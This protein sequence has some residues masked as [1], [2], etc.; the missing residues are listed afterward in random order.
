MT[1]IS[2]YRNSLEQLKG[3]KKALENLLLDKKNISSTI[4]QNYKNTLEARLHIQNVAKETNNQFKIKIDNSVTTALRS[5]FGDDYVFDSEFINKRNSTECILSVKDKYNNKMNLLK[6]KGG[7]VADIVSFALRISL[8]SLSVPRSASVIILDEPAKNISKQYK[9]LFSQFM[10]EVSDKLNIQFIMVTH[11]NSLI[12]CSD[13]F[14]HV[15]L[16]EDDGYKKSVVSR[17]K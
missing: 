5:V 17:K 7:G 1:G 6:D 9:E 10:K 4:E 16:V 13:S 3:Q 8:W 14:T 11:E 15:S 2:K 12:E